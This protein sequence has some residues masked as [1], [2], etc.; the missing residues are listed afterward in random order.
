MDSPATVVLPSLAA[1]L[2]TYYLTRLWI[3]VARERG[4]VGRDINKHKEVYVAEA[5]G[6]PVVLGI[7]TSI[8]LYILL[9]GA[10]GA[11]IDFAM[12]G[13]F[14]TLANMLIAALLG[15]ADDVLGWKKGIP[16]WA[17]VALTFPLALPFVALALLGTLG[18]GLSHFIPL[19]PD[20]AHYVYALILVPAGVVGATNAINMLAGFNGLEA[21][22][23]ALILLFFAIYALL[24]GNVFAATLSLVAVFALSA[25]LFFNWYP[26]KVFPGDTLT[27]AMGA[28]I[29]A[30]AILGNAEILGVIL[31][32]PYFLELALKLRS[33]L[34]LG[35]WAENFGVPQPDGTLRPRY[36]KIYSFT[37]VFQ[38][39][40][41]ITEERLVL[42]ILGVETLIGI[43][44]LFLLC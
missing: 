19:P 15:F 10:L 25:F 13:A 40:P 31:F 38:R 11:S 24:H 1:F 4:L 6:F 42:Y 39:I 37:H 2:L 28:Y 41:G 17:K 16:R 29:A 3:R 18:S 36:P 20:V 23:S 32:I 44:A 5:G 43:A 30:M 9:R 26:A 22:M 27:Y 12:A 8:L 7:S 35:K 33:R 34:E 21:G 14:A